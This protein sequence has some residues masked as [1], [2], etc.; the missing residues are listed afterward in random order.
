MF[1]FPLTHTVWDAQSVSL[2]LGKVMP[3]AWSETCLR[4]FCFPLGPPFHPMLLLCIFSY[5]KSSVGDT[6]PQPPPL[7]SRHGT[8]GKLASQPPPHSGL[9]GVISSSLIPKGREKKR[10]Q[11]NKELQQLGSYTNPSLRSCSW[12]EGSLDAAPP[13]SPHCGTLTPTKPQSVRWGPFSFTLIL[14][15]P[16]SNWQAVFGLALKN[17][18]W[19]WRHPAGLAAL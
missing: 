11:P 13:S 2:R 10:Q 18:R 4:V 1:T 12:A 15:H 7:P 9:K 8:V 19:T 16:L 14:S 17:P 5:T 6:P 3:F